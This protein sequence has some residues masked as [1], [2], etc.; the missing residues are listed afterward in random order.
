MECLTGKTAK[1][2]AGIWMLCMCTT[3]V[4]A[5]PSSD[6]A[7]DASTRA[8]V[9]SGDPEHG[10]QLSAQCT[11]CHGSEGISPD[12]SY[13]HL[14]GQL[15]TYTYKQLHD[16]KE[17]YRPQA[18]MATFV[19][20]L[21]EQ[22]MADLAAWYA[23][24]PLPPASG[25]S[26]QDHDLAERLAQKGDGRRLIPPCASCHGRK[27]QGDIVNMP[28]L[29]GQSAAYLKQTLLDYKQGARANDIYG[30]MRRISEQLSDKEIAALAQYY[31]R[32]NP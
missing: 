24:L 6:V 18:V 22:D 10:E 16:Y 32:M 3:H 8:L 12:P 25:P 5:T 13:P 28:A 26:A 19:A 30:R 4:A 1:R 17:G 21:S 23:Q 27:G 9:A 15:A 11:A 2:Y 29:A 31:A 7:W 20:S 14:A